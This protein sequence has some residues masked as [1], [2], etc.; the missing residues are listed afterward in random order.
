M[1][2]PGVQCALL[3]ALILGVYSGVYEIPYLYSEIAGI[4]RNPVVTDL[5]A[6][7]ERMLTPAGLVQRPISVLS[8]ALNHSVHGEDVFGFHL[9]NVL[10]HIAN[11]ILVY[12][13]AR[14]FFAAPLV[15]GLVFA[16]HP[17]AT[18]CVSQIFGRNYSL[19]SSFSFLALL[20]YMTWR[21]RGALGPGRVAVLAGLFG[22]TVLTKQS[23]VVFPLLLVWY[24]LGR[25]P[26]TEAAV[27]SMLRF[28]WRRALVATA[29]VGVALP[30]VFLYAVPL[31]RTAPVS[32]WTFVLSQLGSLDVLAALYLLSDRTAL[33][34]DLPFHRWLLNAE[35]L[36][37]AA[38]VVAGG[39]LAWRRRGDPMAWLLG[40]MAICLLPTNSVLPKNEILREWRLYPSLFFF[41]LLVG[42]AFERLTTRLRAGGGRPLLLAGAHAA[43]AL[44]LLSFAYADRLQNQAYQ[45][46]LTA[47]K[48]VLQ[49][50]P[51]ST[52][53]MNN[54][55]LHYYGRDD[56]ENA[57][58][59]VGAAARAAPEMAAYWK[60]LAWVEHRLGDPERAQEHALRAVDAA[61]RYGPIKMA[62]R[63]ADAPRRLRSP[64]HLTSLVVREPRPDGPRYIGL[65]Y[66]PDNR[67][68]R[69]VQSPYDLY[70][71]DGE[72]TARSWRAFAADVR[73]VFALRDS[74]Y[75]QQDH[76]FLQDPYAL[77]L[78][79]DWIASAMRL[80]AAGLRPRPLALPDAGDD[81]GWTALAGAPELFGSFPP[82]LSLGGW[83][84][85][86]RASVEPELRPRIDHARASLRQLA[87]YAD[88]LAEAAEAGPDAVAQRGAELVA[89]SDR[90][91]FGELRS[92]VIPVLVAGSG[93]EVVERARAAILRARLRDGDAA[94][95]RYD[96]SDPDER[97]RVIEL[98]RGVISSGASPP[99]NALWLLVSGPRVADEGQAW[100][101]AAAYLDGFRD[102]V[103]AAGIDA[104]RLRYLD[105]ADVP[106][107][108][109]DGRG[110]ALRRIADER[111][112]SGLAF[113]TD[114]SARELRALIEAEPQ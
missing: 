40:A 78:P 35:V 53:A 99:G 54:I 52:D 85:A 101:S 108:E 87:D 64:E 50:Y 44:W 69:G 59:Y 65:R 100:E 72:R 11:T 104:A 83:A 79:T 62:V 95:E 46:G 76:P 96:V 32:S 36:G 71:D 89:E 81:A 73:G 48:Q 105:W 3:A 56:L 90:R 4:Q 91:Y 7:R 109:G 43:L 28:T 82:S 8:Y 39:Y 22:L 41:A 75:A 45:S 80:A 13:L 9:V 2:S 21:P 84:T 98:L 68:M 23:L 111:G 112:V 6:F 113:S 34:H 86:P 18:A 58:R 42:V 16:L 37:G 20:L 25:Q 31:S 60:N 66:R 114:L 63:F 10:I 5:E 55:G 14:R 12:V 27:A 29:C 103:A 88:A 61:Q 74:L 102:E 1:R 26:A 70:R 106:L 57:R 51:Y 67:G 38:L 47:W 33:I 94:I 17:L 15:A 93:E 30:L 110:P 77:V 49:R 24:E 107:P 19:A 97:G 92:Q